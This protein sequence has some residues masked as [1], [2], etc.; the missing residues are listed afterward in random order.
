MDKKSSQWTPLT[1]LELSGKYW[2]SFA[3]HA[4]VE[5]DI[6]T[7]LDEEGM[8]E[9]EIT[10]ELGISRRG[11]T[12][13]LNALSAMN[14]LVKEGDIFFDSRE[15]VEFLSKNSPEYLGYM[16]RHHHYISNAWSTLPDSVRKG[17]PARESLLHNPK[18]KEL[19]AFE[20]GMFNSA[21]LIAPRVA[22]AIDLGGKSSF[23]DLGGGSGTYAI[24]FCLRYP[25]L[26]ATVFDLP[27]VRPFAETLIARFG[28]GSRISFVDGD[29]NKDPIPQG[30]DAA[31]LSH[32][33]HGE[34][35]EPAAGIV[36]KAAASLN[37]GG[38]LLI[39]EF[40]L[41]NG[42][43]S[44]LFPALFSLNM[45]VGTKEGKA[46]THDELTAFMKNASVAG[47]EM[48]DPIA[49]AQSRILKGVKSS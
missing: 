24:H 49:Q 37:P 18:E 27:Q 31:W 13:L 40:I 8:T 44:P 19:E 1:I 2:A 9:E 23:L 21:T 34:G 14:L 3:L 5:L 35:P 28:L 46:Y 20:M 47:I 45:L 30:F 16:I 38:M 7:L 6:F 11:A 4:G 15:A 33:L 26:K 25:G 10:A 36:K 42:G 29:F 17:E 41:D 22:E 39:H 48:L 43:N 32:I 12:A